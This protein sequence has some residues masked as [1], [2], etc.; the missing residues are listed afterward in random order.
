MERFNP[1]ASHCLV[2]SGPGDTIVAGTVGDS[3]LV[4]ANWFRVRSYLV[5]SERVYHGPKQV[6]V[7]GKLA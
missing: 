6:Y 3:G 1:S 5:D 2:S 4:V 7:V